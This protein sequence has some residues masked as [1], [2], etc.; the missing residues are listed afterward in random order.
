MA[1][2]FSNFSC[3]IAQKDI[4]LGVGPSLRWMWSLTAVLDLPSL[5]HTRNLNNDALFHVGAE[6]R[7]C[8]HHHQ[9]KTRGFEVKMRRASPPW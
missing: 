3:D 5:D 2:R 6:S 8:L 7:I 1:H 9:T 4:G